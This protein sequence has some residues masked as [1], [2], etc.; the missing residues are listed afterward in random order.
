MRGRPD[1]AVSSSDLDGIKERVENAAFGAEKSKIVRAALA[2]K[3]CFSTDQIMDLLSLFP[4]D[5][6]K[7]L[8]AKYAYGYVIDRD[9]YDQVT[10]AFEFD[11][12]KNELRAFIHNRR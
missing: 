6:D 4:F 11:K 9:N 10:D 2:A 7:L 3:R 8:L 12:A 5:S 1:C